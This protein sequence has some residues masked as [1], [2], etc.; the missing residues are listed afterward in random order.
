VVGA[1]KILLSRD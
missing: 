1:T